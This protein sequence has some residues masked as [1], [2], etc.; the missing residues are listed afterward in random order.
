MQIVSLGDNL[1]EIS[2]PSFWDNKKI[3]SKCFLLKLLPNMLS[4]NT[5]WCLILDDAVCYGPI[6][7]MLGISGLTTL[8]R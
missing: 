3:I 4:I 1:H 8:Y 7:E 5:L 2:N 6:L